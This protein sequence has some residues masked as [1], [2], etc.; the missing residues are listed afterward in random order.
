MIKTDD[1]YVLF[2]EPKKGASS[3][4][5]QD[6]LS[7]NMRLAMKHAGRPNYVYYGIH[8]CVCGAKSN[9]SDWI[10]HTGQITNSLAVHY[11]EYHRKEVPR[12]EMAKVRALC[13]SVREHQQKWADAEEEQRSISE[14]SDYRFNNPYCGTCGG[15]FFGKAESQCPDCGGTICDCGHCFCDP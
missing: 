4:A 1:K 6:D 9:S 11:L 8:E 2:I 10:L 13:A 3:K 7:A 5:V 15:H 14:R 12:S